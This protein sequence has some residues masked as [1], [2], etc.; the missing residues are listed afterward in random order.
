[1][2]RNRI[3][4]YKPIWDSQ[5]IGINVEKITD[6]LEIEILYRNKDGCRLYPDT[7]TIKKGKAL[8]YPVQYWKGVKLKIIPI[9]D[10][11][12]LDED[13]RLKRDYYAMLVP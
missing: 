1:M 5:S 7:Y 3:E 4:I 11:K 12:I 2:I 10:L 13:E 6:D 8:K 9:K